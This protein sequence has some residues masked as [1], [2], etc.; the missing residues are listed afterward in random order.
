[1]SL[2]ALVAV[3]VRSNGS[4]LAE[5]TGD[6]DTPVAMAVIRWDERDVGRWTL[7]AIMDRRTCSSE[8]FTP[9]DCQKVQALA[10]LGLRA[11]P[12]RA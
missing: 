9:L 11:Y 2:R 7:R 12:G 1:M 5:Q 6:S 8:A 4:W 3:R 10:R